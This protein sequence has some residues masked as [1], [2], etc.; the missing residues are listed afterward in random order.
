MFGDL[1]RLWQIDRSSLADLLYLCAGREARFQQ[2]GTPT[3]MVFT[4]DEDGNHTISLIVNKSLI[5]HIHQCATLNLK[6]FVLKLFMLKIFVH[7]FC[8][9]IFVLL[10]GP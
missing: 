5:R 10:G 6:I 1:P 8:A 9:K 2:A 7:K 3:S 4:R